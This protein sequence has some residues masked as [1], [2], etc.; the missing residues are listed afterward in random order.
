MSWTYFGDER[1]KSEKEKRREYENSPKG[2]ISKE[3]WKRIG[4]RSDDIY[5]QL[6]TI[7]FR[8]HVF[9]SV[10]T[11]VCYLILTYK[12]LDS[13]ANLFLIL[14]ISCTYERKEIGNMKQYY[15][16]SEQIKKEEFEW[17][18]R[19]FKELEEDTSTAE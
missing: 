6:V 7:P 18:E 10:L 3:C 19:K 1:V 5:K 9:Y 17:R 12:N 13:T 15:I 14:Y 2:K 11:L 4:E 8:L 16:E